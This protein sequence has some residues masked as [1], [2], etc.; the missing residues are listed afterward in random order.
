MEESLPVSPSVSPSPVFENSPATSAKPAE[1]ALRVLKVVIVLAL[2]AFGVGVIGNLGGKLVGEL[3]SLWGEVANAR[4]ADPVG[5]INISSEQPEMK[6]ASCIRE[7][8]GRTYLWAGSGVRGRQAGWFD[9]TGVDLPLRQFTYAFG[10]DKIKTID[11]P[12]YQT[13]DGEIVRRLYYERP[14]IGLK[15]NAEARAYPIT[16][17]AKTEVVNDV[18]GTQ[19]VAVTYLP[20][21][22]QAV[23]YERSLDGEPVSF[24]TSGYCYEERF[25]LYDRATD[26]LWMPESQ[27]LTAISGPLAGKV[28]PVIERPEPIAWGK[29]RRRHPDTLV[30]VGADRSQGIPLPPPTELATR[31]L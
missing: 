9:V 2:A 5:Y 8:N 31:P 23:V 14:V 25:V 18:F 28:L 13:T 16:V 7:E 17:L 1:A 26:S 20:L 10:R 19:P 27:G 6:P 22:D 4:D 30:C 3:R 15:I 24:G 21:L 11:Y 29:W 12:I